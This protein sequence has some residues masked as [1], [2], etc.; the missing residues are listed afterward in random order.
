LFSGHVDPGTYS[1]PWDGSGLRDGSYVV[2]VASTDPVT[3]VTQD[4]PITIDTRPPA[5]R[6][7]S[8]RPLVLRVSEPATITATIG[9]R[10]I[11]KTVVAGAFGLPYASHFSVVAV[12]RAGNRARLTR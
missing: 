3:T 7:V 4:V 6:V 2:R 12:D 5:L 10:R 9:R 1:V 8:L 11:V